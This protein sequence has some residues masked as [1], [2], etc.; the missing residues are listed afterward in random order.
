MSPRDAVPPDRRRK[1]QRP[2]RQLDEDVRQRPRLSEGFD[3]LHRETERPRL[4]ASW[5]RASRSTPRWA[6]PPPRGLSRSLA[7]RRNPRRRVRRM[8]ARLPPR[9][10]TDSRNASRSVGRGAQERRAGDEKNVDEGAR[11]SRGARPLDDAVGGDGAPD[12]PS[13]SQERLRGHH[14]VHLGRVVKRDETRTPRNRRRG[15]GASRRINRATRERPTSPRA[16]T[17]D[18]W[19][20]TTP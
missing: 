16:P 11:P 7:R 1:R 12:V 10:H 4:R 5:R 2:E 13:Q 3:F 17:R 14:R 18:A 6:P 8:S 15:K 9:V 20:W 19:R